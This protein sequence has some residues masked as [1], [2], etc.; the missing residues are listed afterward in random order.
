M[1]WDG[2]RQVICVAL[3]TFSAVHVP[4]PML[5]AALA[6]K[7]VPVSVMEVPPPSGPALGETPESVGAGL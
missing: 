6:R 1:E 3:T 2:V 4:P 5:T 7:P